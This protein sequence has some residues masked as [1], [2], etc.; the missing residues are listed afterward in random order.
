MGFQMSYETLTGQKFNSC[1]QLAVLLIQHMPRQE[2]IDVCRENGW[3][4]VLKALE[5]QRFIV[6]NLVH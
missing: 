2:A 1:H 4:G 5:E 3:D 6:T